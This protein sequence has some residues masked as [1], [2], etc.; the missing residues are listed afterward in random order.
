MILFGD[1]GCPKKNAPQAHTKENIISLPIFR[2]EKSDG[3]FGNSRHPS[4]KNAPKIAPISAE[5][6]AAM[7]TDRRIFGTN[8]IIVL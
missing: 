4:T 8:I 1:T 5:P 6:L 3:C 7:T 2:L